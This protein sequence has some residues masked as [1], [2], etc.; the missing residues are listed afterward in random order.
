[1]RQNQ[2]SFSVD[3]NALSVPDDRR[4]LVRL[5]ARL[6]GDVDAAEDITQE[7]LLIALRSAT[8]LRDPSQRDAWL[9]GIARHLC[10]DWIRRRQRDRA[11]TASRHDA[12]KSGTYDDAPQDG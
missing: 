5:C 8:R 4:R 7:T 2:P 9:F 1:M 12:R 3:G 10:V 6:T 11:H